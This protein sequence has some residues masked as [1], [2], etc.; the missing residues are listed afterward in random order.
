MQINMQKNRPNCAK[1]YAKKGKICRKTCK[2]TKICKKKI[3]NYVK[4]IYIQCFASRAEE[5]QSFFCPFFFSYFHVEK[6][7]KKFGVVKKFNFLS[8]LKNHTSF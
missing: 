3:N 4:W 7:K 2:K 1:N 8:K 5:T 6:K